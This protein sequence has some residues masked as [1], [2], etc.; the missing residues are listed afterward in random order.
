MRVRGET[1]GCLRLSM[2]GRRRFAEADLWLAQTLADEAA[3]AVQSAREQQ[4][5]REAARIEALTG[6]TSVLEE[7][8]TSVAELMRVAEPNGAAPDPRAARRQAKAAHATARRVEKGV[9]KL[10]SVVRP[11]RPERT[12]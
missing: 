6:V 7:L 3:L 12:L 5:A 11:D 2:T 4:G 9:R 1:L 10:R 8:E